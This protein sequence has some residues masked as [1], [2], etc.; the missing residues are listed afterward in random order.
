V[1]R[2]NVYVLYVGLYRG[3]ANECLPIGAEGAAVCL[4]L[5]VVSTGVKRGRTNLSRVNTDAYKRQMMEW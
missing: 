1:L 2:K 4:R 5:I 3:M